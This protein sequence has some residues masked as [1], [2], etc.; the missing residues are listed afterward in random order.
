MGEPIISN[1]N[2]PRHPNWKG[3]FQQMPNPT[4][5][6]LKDP[7]F[8]AIWGVIKTWDV[9]VPIHYAGYCGANGSHVMLIL[10]AIR[11]VWAKEVEAANAAAAKEQ[12]QLP[13]GLTET[14][15]STLEPFNL[16]NFAE[17]W[18]VS[19]DGIMRKYEHGKLTAILTAELGLT[20]EDIKTLSGRKILENDTLSM[21]ICSG[22]PIIMKLNGSPIVEGVGQPDGRYLWTK[23]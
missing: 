2:D 14:V 9:N 8:E 23:S 18:H 5:D 13:P 21:D 11:G 17:L 3:V 20:L 19:A 15:F 10:E 16:P 7:M 6:D 1:V 12:V 4:E 22:E